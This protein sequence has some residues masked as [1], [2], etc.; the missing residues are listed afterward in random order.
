MSLGLSPGSANMVTVYRNLLKLYKH[1]DEAAQQESLNALPKSFLQKIVDIIGEQV[2]RS[3]EANYGEVCVFDSKERLQQAIKTVTLHELHFLQETERNKIFW[4][5]PNDEDNI[6]RLLSN[7]HN[8]LGDLTLEL[9]MILKTWSKEGVAEEQRGTALSEIVDFLRNYN[10]Q[11]LVL[12]HF[13]LKFLPGVF[14]GQ[15]WVFRLRELAL[16]GNH[17][18]LLPRQIGL[19]QN[20]THLNLSNN[21]LTSFPEEIGLLSN[22][23][24]LDLSENKLTLFPTYI[25]SLESLK[26]LAL[27]KNKLK[28]LPEEIRLPPYL[29]SLDLSGNQLTSLPR[30]I[31]QFGSLRLLALC[32]NQFASFPDQIYPLKELQT[33]YL[34]SNQLTS[35][36]DQI[37]QFRNL[38]MLDLRGNRGLK[39]VP[40]S[41][42]DL[43]RNCTVN[44]IE[45]RLSESVLDD[46]QQ[47]FSAQGYT[48]P[49]IRL[50][51]DIAH[52]PPPSPQEGS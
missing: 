44:M 19:L 48:G 35:L 10:K 46:L 36:P 18:T 52:I 31:G 20:L 21:E 8:S 47:V 13:N 49:K 2:E 14:D 38:T 26:V 16:V 39:S 32:E 45:T 50:K 9:A 40:K 1:K 30:K 17:L 22:L 15:S 25:D 37:G 51:G 29:Q 28:R 7:M 6:P 33:L 4:R 23:T 3:V 43:G 12:N 5:I 34:S 42:F 11:K 27:S 24:H 41:L